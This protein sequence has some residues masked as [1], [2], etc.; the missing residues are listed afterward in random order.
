MESHK[1]S[2]ITVRRYL[3]SSAVCR[4]YAQ[5]RILFDNQHGFELLHLKSNGSSYT[6]T[7]ETRLAEKKLTFELQWCI[8][9]DILSLKSLAEE[10]ICALKCKIIHANRPESFIVYI[11][12]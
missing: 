5:L 1:G 2:V 10:R 4:L 8:T 7:N 3:S 11:W 6:I 9:Q 12:I